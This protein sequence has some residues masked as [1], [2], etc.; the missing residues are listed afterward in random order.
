[1]KVGT[2]AETAGAV[3]TIDLDAIAGNYAR[4]RDRVAASGATCAAVVKADAYGLGVA[5]VAPALADAGARVFF[6]ATIDEGVELRAVLAD[7]EIHVLGGPMPRCEA[8]FVEHA[9]VPVLNSL[10]DT[11]AWQRFC[12]GRGEPLAA[13]LHLDTGMARL[14]LPGSELAT[15]MEAPERL[16][17][18]AVV[19]LMSHLACADE[20][21]H[22]K[23]EDQLRVFRAARAAL[24]GLAGTPASFAN[25]SGIFLGP[26]YHFDLVRPGVA[27]YGVAPQP[28]HENPMAD[29]VGL[30]GKILQIRDVDTPETVGYGATHR[31]TGPARIATVGV[32]YADG[33]LRSLSDAGSAY[34]GE[35]RAPV[36]GRV[37]MDLITLDVSALPPSA[38]QPGGF[39]DLIGPHNPVDRIAEEAGT[40]GYEIL[41][42]LGRRY[43]RIYS[44]GR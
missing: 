25:S 14:G 5:E 31:V 2:S 6:V 37:S 44:G 30:R 1:V 29:V 23:N 8:A 38:A 43:H 20:P 4:L 33:Y 26:E 42:S 9:L 12:R 19:S 7:A 21:D 22:P 28:G 35:V 16:D 39:V 34:V 36:V 18:I 11:D 10:G 27:L 17:G 40:I 24:G 41:T 3:L 15:L 13:D 32:G